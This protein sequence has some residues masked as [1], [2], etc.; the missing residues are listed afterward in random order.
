MTD[1]CFQLMIIIENSELVAIE[2]ECKLK[3]DSKKQIKT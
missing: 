3:I 2:E 1:S